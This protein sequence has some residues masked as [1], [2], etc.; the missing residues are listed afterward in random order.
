MANE[1]VRHGVML[2]S[3]R[4]LFHGK[5]QKLLR[6]YT[7][8]HII[9]RTTDN[10]RFLT[11]LP[12]LRTSIIFVS[13]TVP[14]L[15]KTRAARQTL[16]QQPSL[17]VVAL[18]V[19]NRRDCCSHVIRTKTQKFLLGSSSVN[20]IVRTVSTIVS[21]KDCFDPRL[22]SSLAKQVHAHSSI[23]SRR[24]SIHRHRVLITI[25]HKLSGRRVTSR[26]FVSGHA[27]SGRQ[28]GVL[29]GANYGGA[30]DLIICTVHGKVIRV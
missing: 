25:Y 10:R 20:S 24:L 14:K 28:T 9:N 21:N 8:Y 1:V 17:Q 19:F 6:H 4:S 11:V 2:M 18:S 27:I 15:S 30:T 16:T 22:L 12:K 5:L 29:R 23:P 7:K 3:S 13:F 26:L